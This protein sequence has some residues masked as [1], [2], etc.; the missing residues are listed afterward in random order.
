MMR[1]VGCGEQVRS[2]GVFQLAKR[3]PVHWY[4]EPRPFT[5]WQLEGERCG[6]WFAPKLVISTAQW[7][8]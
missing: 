6:P 3:C 5:D 8:V 2:S 1:S 4:P 7:T